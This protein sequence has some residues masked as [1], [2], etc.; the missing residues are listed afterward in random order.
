[1]QQLREQAKQLE[2][3]VEQLKRT[4]A[5]GITAIAAHAKHLRRE[6]DVKW[7]QMAML[8]LQR[9]NKAEY[10]N[11]RLKALL[12]NQMKIDESLRAVVMKR[13]VLEVSAR[14]LLGFCGGLR[15]TWLRVSRGWTL[16]LRKRRRRGGLSLPLTTA[17]S[18]WRSW[19]RRRA[20]CTW[21][22]SFS[23][24]SRRERRLSAAR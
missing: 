15:L 18:S 4:R 8:E 14:S 7:M 12:A 2:A 10:T 1:M 16:S 13:S 5:A 17:A 22:Q 21:S 24:A 9:R 23:S 6:A 3:K 19:R 20:R 11:R